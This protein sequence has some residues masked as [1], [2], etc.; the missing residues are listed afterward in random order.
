MIKDV[1]IHETPSLVEVIS[2]PAR[3]AEIRLDEV[4]RI[5]I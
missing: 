4:E 2:P 3:R 1:I 5:A